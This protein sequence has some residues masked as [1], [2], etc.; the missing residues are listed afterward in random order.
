[1]LSAYLQAYELKMTKLHRLR[2]KGE[3]SRLS[4]PFQML[5]TKMMMTMAVK[6]AMKCNNKRILCPIIC[7]CVQCDT[8]SCWVGR[9][10]I[11]SHYRVPYHVKKF[12]II[13]QGHNEDKSSSQ[14]PSSGELHPA[15]NGRKTPYSL[16]RTFTFLALSRPVQ[17]NLISVC[18]FGLAHSTMGIVN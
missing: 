14:A 4:S 11:V 3:L 6:T 8:S 9:S 1:M 7:V 17:S 18:I 5:I 16:K 10:R 12:K 2:T 15:R 13:W